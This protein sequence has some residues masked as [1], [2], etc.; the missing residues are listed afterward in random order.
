M[1]QPTEEIPDDPR[2]Y[3]G[4]EGTDIGTVEVEP[5]PVSPWVWVAIGLGVSFLFR[6]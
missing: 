5:V 1:R 3:F 2:V 4:P 6:K